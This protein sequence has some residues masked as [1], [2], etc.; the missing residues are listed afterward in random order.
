MKLCPRCQ[1]NI[2]G[3]IHHCDCCGALL[4]DKK[5]LFFLGI[6]SLPQCLLL[7]ELTN[8]FFDEI[9]PE[10]ASQYSNFLDE[11]DFMLICYPDSMNKAFNVKNNVRYSPKL[12]K[13]YITML[14]PFN[15]FIY[16]NKGVKAVLITE[17]ILN[18]LR[19]L[20]NRLH[21]YKFNIDQYVTDCEKKL[22]LCLLR[23]KKAKYIF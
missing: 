7:S 9:E 18:G 16:A 5:H 19:L 3:L 20:Q 11:I 1:A 12:K 22:E 2:E 21:K 6:Y 8:I 17:A 13:G 14:I 15:D 10:N 4:N 23:L